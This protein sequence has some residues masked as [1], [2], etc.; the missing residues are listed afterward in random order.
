MCFDFIKNKNKARNLRRFSIE[1][2][3]N[4]YKKKHLTKLKKFFVNYLRN[5]FASSNHGRTRKIIKVGPKIYQKIY[6]KT[7][8]TWAVALLL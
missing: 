6:L 7:K 1:T 5:E 3:S 2:K 8:K 4:K